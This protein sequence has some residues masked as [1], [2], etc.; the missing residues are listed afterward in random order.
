MYLR[1][2]FY[3]RHVTA[4]TTLPHLSTVKTL[5]ILPTALILFLI[6]S[7]LCLMLE[8]CS[9]PAGTLKSSSSVS[10][11]SSPFRLSTFTNISVTALGQHRI[12]TVH[13]VI[14][15]IIENLA[16]FL[17]V[18]YGIIVWTHAWNIGGFIMVP[19]CHTVFSNT[20]VSART[21][22][23]RLLRPTRDSTR[24]V[25]TGSPDRWMA[26]CPQSSCVPNSYCLCHCQQKLLA[27]YYSEF[28]PSWI[29]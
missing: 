2:L 14:G 19:Y 24:V 1:Q 8:A 10:S 6:T 9:E 25:D 29:M 4:C 17:T 5:A 26:K 27:W 13:V 18:W 21:L 28:S 12:V 7:F 23:Q 11:S 20:D 15:R 3:N 16:F 22:V